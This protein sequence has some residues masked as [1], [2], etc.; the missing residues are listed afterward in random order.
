MLQNIKS[1]YVIKQLL[2]YIEYKKLLTLIKYNKQMQ[3]LLD[4]NINNIY[5]YKRE[6]SNN[7]K[8]WNRERIQSLQWKSY[9]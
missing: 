1:S 2:Y 5:N 7:R 4:I 8:R 3:D 6:M 9:I